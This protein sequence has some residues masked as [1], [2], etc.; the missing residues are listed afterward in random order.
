[1]APARQ[2]AVR[3]S[4]NQQ[5]CSQPHEGSR[6]RCRPQMA[7]ESGASMP[8][9]G[10]SGDM[11]CM[12]EHAAVSTCGR[13]RAAKLCCLHSTGAQ[14][15]RKH[16]ANE[17]ERRTESSALQYAASASRHDSQQPAAGGTHPPLPPPPSLLRG[18]RETQRRGWAPGPAACGCTCLSR[19]PAA[20]GVHHAGHDRSSGSERINKVC[21]SVA[22]D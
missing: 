16:N 21:V 4:K 6:K 22:S 14:Q 3:N 17:P 15:G 9:R 10:E 20:K 8:A 7:L 1:M 19:P 18:C 12:L 13:R 2:V 11:A 5:V